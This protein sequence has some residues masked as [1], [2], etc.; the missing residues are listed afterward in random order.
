[1]GNFI[2]VPQQYRVLLVQIVSLGWNTYLSFM[3]VGGGTLKEDS[4]VDNTF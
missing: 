3:S 1:M 2:V 4:L